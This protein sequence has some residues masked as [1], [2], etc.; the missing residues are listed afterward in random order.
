MCF[1]AWTYAVFFYFLTSGPV[2][3]LLTLTATASY[4]FKILYN[5]WSSF[6]FIAFMETELI[7]KIIVSKLTYHYPESDCTIELKEVEVTGKTGNR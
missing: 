4:H 6:Q 3:S 2:F 1:M 7:P 5:S